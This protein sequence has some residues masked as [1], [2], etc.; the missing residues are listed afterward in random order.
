MTEQDTAS[1]ELCCLNCSERFSDADVAAITARARDS[2]CIL[3]CAACGSH[4]L[5]RSAPRPGLDTPPGLK[6]IRVVSG[7]IDVADAFRD[8][9][10]PGVYVHPRSAGSSN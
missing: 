4:N 3:T 5:V 7:D 2:A 1:D 10:E 6:V 8:E 9:V